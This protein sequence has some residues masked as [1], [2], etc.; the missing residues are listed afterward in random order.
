MK[1]ITVAITLSESS[2]SVWSLK[3]IKA[4]MINAAVHKATEKG[5]EIANL[6]G[7]IGHVRGAK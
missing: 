6:E 1:R 4:A 7:R 2:A 3:E 5:L